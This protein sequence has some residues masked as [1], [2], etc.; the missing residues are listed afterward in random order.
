LKTVLSHSQLKLCY[1]IS[2]QGCK[3]LSESSNWF[4]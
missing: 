4:C 1:L 2:L 3:C